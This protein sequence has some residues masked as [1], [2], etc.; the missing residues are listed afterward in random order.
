MAMCRW[1]GCI[2][3]AKAGESCAVHASRTGTPCPICHGSGSHFYAGQGLTMACQTCGGTGL[4]DKRLPH[5]RRSRDED[6]VDQRG[7]IQ[8]SKA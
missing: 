4:A 5:G 6:P 8:A 7:L 3:E 2:S 1:P